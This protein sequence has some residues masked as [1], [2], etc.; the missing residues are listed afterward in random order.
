[1]HAQ[2]PLC[3]QSTVKFL[4]QQRRRDAPVRRIPI[5]FPNITLQLMKLADDEMKQIKETGWLREVAFKTTPDVTK[6][7]AAWSGCRTCG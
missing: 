7:R 2:R 1:M 3:T 4:S 6:V 5:C